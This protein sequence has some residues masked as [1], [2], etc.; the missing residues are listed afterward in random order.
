MLKDSVLSYFKSNTDIFFRMYRIAAKN[1]DV[2]AVHNMRVSL[3]RIDTLIRMLNYN[4]KANYRL[5]N[6]YKP[7]LKLFKLAGNLRDFQVQVLLIEELKQNIFIDDIIQKKFNLKKD[8]FEKKFFNMNGSF[9]F[10]LIKR[11]FHLAEYYIF[12]ASEQELELQISSYQKSRK[13]LLEKYS[14]KGKR[15]FNLHNAR[16]MIKDLSYLIEM[17]GLG[18][19]KENPKFLKYKETG[20]FLG[21]LHDNVVMLEYLEEIIFKDSNFITDNSDILRV[22][23][24]EKKEML[25]DNYLE[26][27]KEWKNE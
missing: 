3:K 13:I 15:S 18:N 17:S 24:Q 8:F 27:Y 26:K 11:N 14:G 12:N 10:F 19:F 21:D 6:C 23:L 16:K 22:N 20:H 25:T 2:D 7:L 5:K 1:A 9:N 4:K